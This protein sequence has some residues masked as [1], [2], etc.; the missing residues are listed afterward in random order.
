MNGRMSW[1]NN[2]K[3]NYKQQKFLRHRHSSATLLTHCCVTTSLL[4][5][6][7]C[8]PLHGF[9]P[10]RWLCFLLMLNSFCLPFFTFLCCLLSCLFLLRFTSFFS[11]FCEDLDVDGRIILN[12]IL[13]IVDGVERS[14]ERDLQAS[15]KDRYYWP[16][17][18]SS[19]T[20][21]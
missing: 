10:I 3:V 5:S 6:T 2:A 17:N 8:Q 13:K 14:K 19:I 18:S 15:I 7:I 9:N 4:L 12:L 21:L 1:T 16:F 11:C 20:R